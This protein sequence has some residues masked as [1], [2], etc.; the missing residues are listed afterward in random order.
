MGL[1]APALLLVTGCLLAVTIIL[2]R[3][4]ADAGAPMLW[5]LTLVMSGAGLALMGVALLS[6]Q[7]KGNWR[8]LLLY[9]LG[10]GAFQALPSAM[11]Y[12]SVAHVGAG[13]VSLAF[14]FPLLVTYVLALAVGMERFA[15]LRALGVTVALAGGL[16]LAISKLS[17]LSA[18]EEAVVWVL[19]ASAI[20]LVLACGNLFRT[21]FWP[22][23]APP[24]LL[25]ALMLLL[26]AILTVPFAAASEGIAGA[27]RLWDQGFLLALTGLNTAA[28]ALQFVAYFRLQ[29]TAG[30]VYLSQIGSVAAAVGTPVAVLFLGETLP[31]GFA[32]ALLLIVGGAVLFQVAARRSSPAGRSVQP[33]EVSSSSSHDSRAAASGRTRPRSRR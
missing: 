31:E 11:A 9:G 24:L 30:P 26:A 19:V 1:Q 3:L 6:G 22:E 5:F 27:A 17:G 16:L 33:S 15:P 23:G 10:A 21:R 25:A 18:D 4:A 13:Y 7:A 32:V 2:S 29:Q 8:R 12:L 28:F 14:A 20:P